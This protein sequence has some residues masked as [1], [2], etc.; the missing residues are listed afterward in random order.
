[1]AYKTTNES[2]VTRIQSGEIHLLDRLLEANR[3]IIYCTARKY[4]T[5]AQ[6][7][8][9]IDIEDLTQAAAI[10]IIE[11][12][13]A[14]DKEKGAFL[15]LAMLYMK[16]S[17]REAIGINT[18]KKRI[19]NMPHASLNAPIDTE[20]DTPLIDTLIDKAAPD[21]AEAAATADL[22]RTVRAAVAALPERQYMAIKHLLDGG[23][24]VNDER[25][26]INAFTSLRRNIKL[27]RLWEEYDNAP[28]Q[29][30]GVNAWRY[31]NT[32]TTEAAVLTRERIR[33]NIKNT[34]PA[35]GG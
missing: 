7:N 17:I 19:E 12:V 31:T 4:I 1:M 14:W 8:R 9:A 18:T 29:H 13:P 10:G 15:T 26:R 23:A 2:I 34:F 35:A 16:H 24:S 27:I 22:C 25:G 3:G 30:K 6:N 28:Y 21:P 5:A 20:N 32:S 33:D 11:A